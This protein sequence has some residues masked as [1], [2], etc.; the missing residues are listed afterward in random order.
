MAM[1]L[2][3]LTQKGDADG[4]YDLPGEADTFNRPKA[5]HPTG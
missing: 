4:G 2:R 5:C 1:S 3:E